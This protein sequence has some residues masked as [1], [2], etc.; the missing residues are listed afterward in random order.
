[1]TRLNG[2]QYLMI[3]DYD[4]YFVAID[5]LTAKLADIADDDL[6][7]F[8]QCFVEGEYM[9]LV[10]FFYG[11]TI[12]RDLQYIGKIEFRPNYEVPRRDE[13]IYR[14]YAQQV[15]QTVYVVDHNGFLYRIAW[16]DIKEGKYEKKLIR[17]DL[18]NFFV[19]KILGIAILDIV[20]T[21][22]LDDEVE[23]DLTNLSNI[24]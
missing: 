3:A 13:P 16:Q 24:P 10:D 20:G 7:N 15:G 9:L 19:D 2:S 22:Y 23:L 21:L 12:L 8:S 4:S 11:M 1:M 18:M 17:S 6:G 5:S 14:R